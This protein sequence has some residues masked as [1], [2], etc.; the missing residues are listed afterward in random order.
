MTWFNIS[1]IELKSHNLTI[2]HSNFPLLACL[3]TLYGIVVFS[4]FTPQTFIYYF[5]NLVLR[6]SPPYVFV[7]PLMFWTGPARTDSYKLYIKPPTACSHRRD[8]LRQY[9]RGAVWAIWI[10]TLTL[11]WG[12]ME[13]WHLTNRWPSTKAKLWLEAFF[14]WLPWLT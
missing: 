8:G 3:H 6:A 10:T 11:G 1:S 12:G 7:G 13:A 4:F 5:R 2:R 14:V 9:C